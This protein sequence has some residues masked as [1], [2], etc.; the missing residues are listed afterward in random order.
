MTDERQKKQAVR[1]FE[2]ENTTTSKPVSNLPRDA[3]RGNDAKNATSGHNVQKWKGKGNEQKRCEEIIACCYC[4][5]N[6][7]KNSKR[8]YESEKAERKY[9][10]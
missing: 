3:N 6:C 4:C 10:C 5:G 2:K 8:H 7:G 9:S 1:A